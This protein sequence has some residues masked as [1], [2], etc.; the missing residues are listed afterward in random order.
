VL[1][2]KLTCSTGIA[3]SNVYLQAFSEKVTLSDREGELAKSDF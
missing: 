2:E 1:E 3:G